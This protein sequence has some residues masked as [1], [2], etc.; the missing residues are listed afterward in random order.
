MGAS[1]LEEGNQRSR[2]RRL[3]RD[4]RGR[5]ALLAAFSLVLSACG[6]TT[7]GGTG[8]GAQSGQAPSRL[9]SVTIAVA[10]EVDTLGTK[11]G[12]GDTYAGEFDFLS[13][14]PLA[15]HNERA[16][17]IPLLAAELPSRDA[18]TWIVNPDGTMATTW[19]IRP[20]A[21][22]HDGRPVGPSDFILTLKIYQDPQLPVSSRDPERFMDRIEAVDAN[23]F[24]IHW[25]RSYPWA[26]Q[27]I[28][29]QLEP[30]LPDHLMGRVYETSDPQTFVNHEL[31][32]RTSYVG[33]GPFVLVERVPGSQLVYRAFDQYF[34]GRPK[35]DQV[36]IRIIEDGSTVVANVLSGAVDV[37]VGSTLGQIAG[38]TIKQQ[39][40]QSGDGEVII[41]PVRFRYMEFQHNPT[42]NR[43]PALLD[44][45]G[46]RAMAHAIDRASLAEVVTAGTSPATEIYL[47]PSD[48]WHG[49]ALQAAAKYAYD[50]ARALA[51]LGELGWSRRGEQLSSSSGEPFVL[52]VRTTTGSDNQTESSIIAADLSKLGIQ[53]NI[54]VL[55]E[56]AQ[57]DN[58]YRTTFP[59]VNVTARSIRV[60]ETMGIWTSGQCPNPSQ[61][62]RG[63][64][65]GCWQN[66]EYD[67]LFLVASTSLDPAERGN[68][69]VQGMKLL[70]E[71]VGVLGISYNSENLAVRKG[72][73]G[74]GPRS[75]EQVG[76]TWNIYE[77]HW[78]G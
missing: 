72:L 41:T 65:R 66:E 19:R 51:L 11:L 68:A 46:R 16:A 10:G 21:R 22:W 2:P 70:T 20:N 58:E 7:P 64:N 78:R 30:L 33:T 34:M 48:Q 69:M 63:A 76:N 25:R 71:N 14:S 35:L 27:L 37:T 52:E 15:V 39:W 44:A 26:N 1:R 6:P 3:E 31:W 59:G 36:V 43:Q 18:G 60:P 13:S 5:A 12:G 17:A 8:S 67:R 77:W 49:P 23:T 75:S 38:S 53:A 54:N 62:F 55:S 9:Q 73:V 47:S 4:V 29:R 61:N 57:R 74:P 42:H 32:H 45:R 40:A 50:P 24:V 56:A 28:A